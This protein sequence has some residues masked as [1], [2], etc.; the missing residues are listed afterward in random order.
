MSDKPTRVQ[1][2]RAPKFGR[3]VIIGGAL[4][5]IGT[6]VA[7]NLYPADPSV[8]FWALFAYFA[9]FG[10][11]AGIV[12]GAVVAIIFDT[13]SRRRPRTVE[14]QREQISGE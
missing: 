1:V 13:V 3:F 2:R 10:V 11:T 8:G 7:T 4:G 5:A 9:L 12:L 6:L 14:V